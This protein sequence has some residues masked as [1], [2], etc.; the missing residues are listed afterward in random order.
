MFIQFGRIVFARYQCISD[1]IQHHICFIYGRATIFLLFGYNLCFYLKCGRYFIVSVRPCFH[2]QNIETYQVCKSAVYHIKV[3]QGVYFRNLTCTKYMQCEN[4]GFM[5]N[6]SVFSGTYTIKCYC[7]SLSIIFRYI[8][9]I[10]HSV[11]LNN[12]ESFSQLTERAK[13][14]G[15]NISKV[16]F[17]GYF[18][19]DKLQKLHDG[20]IEIRT[21]LKIAVRFFKVILCTSEHIC[22][23]V[24]YCFRSFKQL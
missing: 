16:V 13:G 19:H 10:E 24:R 20:A 12:M 11:E 5:R 22:S 1:T 8:E 6:V 3:S 21:K 23:I 9:F 7:L 2:C 18:A 17:R 14:I 4:C 15:Y